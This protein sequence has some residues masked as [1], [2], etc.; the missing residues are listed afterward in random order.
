M[1]DTRRNMMYLRLS[2]EDDEVDSAGR[3]ESNSITNQRR[4]LN[5]YLTSHPE[6]GSDFEEI[7]DDGFS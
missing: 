4:I 1:D 7:V 6:L 3:D 2:L 5:D